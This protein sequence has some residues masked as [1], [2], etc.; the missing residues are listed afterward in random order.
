MEPI[1][2]ALGL[3]KFIPDVVEMIGGKEKAE[4]TK[5]VIDIATTV[6]GVS[7]PAEALKKI[8]SDPLAENDFKHEFSKQKLDMEKLYLKDRKDARQMYRDHHVATDQTSQWIM[9][10]NLIIVFLLVTINVAAIHFFK[11]DGVLIAAVSNI[12][13]YV[14]NSLLS[15]RQQVCNFRFGSSAGSKMKSLAKGDDDV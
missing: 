9:K 2:I 6:T 15:E 1:S 8:E 10:W 4:V 14:T 7:D 3:A 12:I 13:G 5:R 11:D